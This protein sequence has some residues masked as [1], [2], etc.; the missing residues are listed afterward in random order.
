MLKYL[1]QNLF[2]LKGR[3]N[4]KKY[5]IYTLITTISF[6]PYLLLHYYMPNAISSNKFILTLL[7]IQGIIAFF[8]KISL[9]IRRFHDLG[10]TGMWVVLN[11]IMPGDSNLSTIGALSLLGYLAVFK[12]DV[13][14]NKYGEDPLAN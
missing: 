7:L 14:P 13:G 1:R 2:T 10:K 5:I 4:R 9:Q 3:I 8:I 6:A 11:F 12:G